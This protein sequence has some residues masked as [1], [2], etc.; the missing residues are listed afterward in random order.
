MS[1]DHEIG[2]GGSDGLIFPKAFT[3]SI[4]KGIDKSIPKAYLK[5]LDR[6][7]LYEDIVDG[8]KF[9][10]SNKFL[11]NDSMKVSLINIGFSFLT[12]E[13]KEDHTL[14]YC[15]EVDC[16]IDLNK[17]LALGGETKSP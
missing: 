5:G 15:F 1:K 12:K 7:D 17:I 10:T 13:E 11:K 4:Y 16:Q 2:L 6:A 14:V 3:K 9:F 8:A